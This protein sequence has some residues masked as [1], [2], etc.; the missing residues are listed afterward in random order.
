MSPR[1]SNGL[2]WFGVVGGAVAWAVQFVTNLAFSFAQCNQPTTRWRLPVHGWQI[3]LSAAAVI[4]V[5]ASMAAC[6]SIFRRTFRIDDVFGQERRGDGSVPPL[7]RVHF[8]AIVG[9]V[10]NVLVL[11][12]IVMTG[13]GAPLLTV[14]QQS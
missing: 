1:R 11:P 4:V 8:L 3:G 13:I 5:L 12:I 10:V 14:C 7:G 9:F 2:L 6:T